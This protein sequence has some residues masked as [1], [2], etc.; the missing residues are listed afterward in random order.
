MTMPLCGDW[1]EVKE[2]GVNGCMIL[3]HPDSPAIAPS[4][5][6]RRRLCLHPDGSA[7]CYGGSASD[8]PCR[9]A[10]GHWQQQGQKLQLT[11]PG[12]E[13]D[14]DIDAVEEDILII[15]KR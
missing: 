14:Y 5:M 3:R 1:V 7:E 10:T 8:R 6:P 12:W 13:G 15:T 9:D 11:L 2:E 4:R